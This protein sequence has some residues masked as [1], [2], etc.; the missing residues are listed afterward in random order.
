MA[1]CRSSRP[2]ILANVYVVP[3]SVVPHDRSRRLTDYVLLLGS[4]RSSRRALASDSM[5]QRVSAPRTT[6]IDSGRGFAASA[7]AP[8][9]R[10]SKQRDADFTHVRYVPPGPPLGLSMPGAA[11]LVWLPPAPCLG[12]RRRGRGLVALFLFAAAVEL[13]GCLACACD[14]GVDLGEW[15][16][17]SRPW[18]R[19][20][21]VGESVAADRGVDVEVR[22]GHAAPSWLVRRA[23]TPARGVPAIARVSRGPSRPR[24]RLDVGGGAGAALGDG[25]RAAL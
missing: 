17:S 21:A 2:R 8:L 5:R 12:R 24:D 15:P 3:C 13:L 16:R 7:S 6:R 22:A 9:D 20:G 1:S 10:F 4:R 23:R 18:R 19:G 11:L 25:P 14:A